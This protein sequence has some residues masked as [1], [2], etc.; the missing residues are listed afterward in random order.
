MNRSIFR[1]FIAAICLIVTIALVTPATALNYVDGQPRYVKSDADLKCED[2]LKAALE[3]LHNACDGIGRNR[4]C[5]GNNQISA[6]AAVDQALKFDTVGDIAAIQTISS[7]VT[8]PMNVDTGT[9]GVSLLKLQANLPDT[10]PGQNVTF[11]VYGDTQIDNPSGDMQSFYFSS[12]LGNMDC[13]TIPDSGIVVRSPNHMK[14]SFKANGVEITIASTI[15]LNAEKGK[16]L[17]VGL[18]E[19][20]AEVK[21]GGVTQTLKPGQSTT[22]PLGGANGLEASGQPSEPEEESTDDSLAPVLATA[23]DFASPA[24]SDFVIDG[25]VTAKV[26]NTLVIGD[27]TIQ[28]NDS[29]T[30]INRAQVGQ[31]YHIEGDFVT[32]ANGKKI[33]KPKLITRTDDDGLVVKGNASNNTKGNNG[34]GKG[35]NSNGN[36][37]GNANGATG[38]NGGSGSNNGNSGGGKGGK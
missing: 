30:L 24:S 36:A 12:G 11:L 26:G 19:G 31:C 15:T 1:M 23:D 38:N 21:A 5:Y 37:N 20:H 22:V 17:K 10:L 9:W 35:G 6:T 33:I 25:C 8:S 3:Q 18:L 14:V 28:L 4:A 34:K 29:S 32:D 7:L 16:G 13:K 27:S 2:I